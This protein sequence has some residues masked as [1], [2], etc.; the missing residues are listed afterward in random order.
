[1]DRRDMAAAAQLAAQMA[2]GA[3]RLAERRLEEIV[4]LETRLHLVRAQRELVLAAMAALEAR[5][6][7]EPAKRGPRVH[8]IPLD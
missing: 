2:I 4:P 5:E 1:M 6:R 3:A 8:K 7:R